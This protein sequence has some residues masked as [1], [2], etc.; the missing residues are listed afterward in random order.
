MKVDAVRYVATCGVCQR[1]KAGR[2]LAGK[3]QSL[4]F[5]CG[6]GMML[7]LILWLIY[8]IPLGQKMLFGSL[9]AV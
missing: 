1:V 2:G 7:T 9:W 6:F 8:H 5:L 4:M 3:L